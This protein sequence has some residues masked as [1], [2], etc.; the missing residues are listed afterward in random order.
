MDDEVFVFGSFWLMPAERRSHSL[1]TRNGSREVARIPA[2]GAAFRSASDFRP[3]G[4]ADLP[5]HVLGS[6]GGGTGQ[7][8]PADEA[9]E[10][11]ARAIARG[12]QS[13]DRLYH[14]ELVRF[15][16]ELLLHSS[17]DT[18]TSAAEDCF[19]RA[20]ELAHDQGALFWELRVA[21]CL[22][23]LRVTQ[24][25][26]EEAARLLPPVCD[27]FT[28]GFEA[29]DLRAAR[30][31][32]DTLCRRASRVCDP[33][34]VGGSPREVGCGDRRRSEPLRRVYSRG[35]MIPPN[36]REPFYGLSN[37]RGGPHRALNA[38]MQSRSIN[39]GRMTHP[40]CP[41][42]AHRR[43]CARCFEGPV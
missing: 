34:I 18:H 9:S 8:R 17:A 24:G 27:R 3:H 31:L 29:P 15:M 39:A 12:E 33:R 30:A 23:R 40:L 32:L 1:S 7:P 14:A 2:C 10:T 41:E 43:R 37:R 11:I 6:S 16:G 38:L 35:T 5:R 13:G 21:L 19:R 28:E 4:L 36:Q 26:V 20:N 25:R 42:L 22:A